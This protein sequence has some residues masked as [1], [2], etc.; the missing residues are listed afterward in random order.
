MNQLR[1]KFENP[2][3]WVKPE[4]DKAL[5]DARQA[6]EEYGHHLE[7]PACLSAALEPLHQCHGILYML[8][9]HGAALLAEEMEKT[10]Q[11]LL[12][13]RLQGHAE[14][15]EA[16]VQGALALDGYLERLNRGGED[17]PLGLLSLLNDL[18]ASRQESLVS[19]SLLFNP[20]L[21]IVPQVA[22]TGASLGRSLADSARTLRPYYQ[23]ALLTWFRNPGDS[24]SLQQMKLVVRNLES[25][26]PHPRLRQ[27]WWIAGGLLEALS[28]RGLG[29]SVTLRLL[30]GD[31]DRI[32]KRIIAGEEA[33]LVKYPPTALLKNMLFYIGRSTSEGERVSQ[34][35]EAFDLAA[36]TPSENQLAALQTSLRGKRGEALS[37]VAAELETALNVIKLR[38]EDLSRRRQVPASE[39]EPLCTPLKQFADTLSLVGLSLER[40]I[41]LQSMS[42]VNGLIQGKADADGDT[43]LEIAASLL[44]VENGLQLLAQGE[45][46]HA[47]GSSEQQQRSLRAEAEMRQL[48]RTTLLEARQ[49]IGEIKNALL[50]YLGTQQRNRNLANAPNLMNQVHGALRMLEL[51]HAA[52]LCRQLGQFIEHDILGTDIPAKAKLDHLAEAIVSLEYYLEAVA[53]GRASLDPILA[54][55]RKAVVELGYRVVKPDSAMDDNI[56]TLDSIVTRIET[57]KV[58][59]KPPLDNVISLPREDFDMDVAG[60]FAEEVSDELD[61]LAENCARLAAGEEDESIL[62][63]IRRTFHTLKGSGRVA[64]ADDIS[65]L[66]ISFERF[67][68][69][70]MCGAVPMDQKGI[71]LLRRSRDAFD[72]LLDAYLSRKPAPVEKNDLIAQLEDQEEETPEM[73][74]VKAEQRIEDA[75][76]VAPVEESGKGTAEITPL[77][78]SEAVLER[79]VEHT[80][81]TLGLIEAFVNEQHKSAERPLLPPALLVAIDKLNDAAQQSGLEEFAQTTELL[82][83]YTHNIANKNLPLS[84]EAL[85]I[86]QE[87]C[88]TSKEMLLSLQTPMREEGIPSASLEAEQAAEPVAVDNEEQASLRKIFAEE[89]E[90]LLEQAMHLLDNWSEDPSLSAMQRILHTLKGSARMAAADTI[91]NFAHEVESWLESIPLASAAEASMKAMLVGI[92]DALQEMLENLDRNLS[93]DAPIKLLAQLDSFK[94]QQVQATAATEVSISEE[95]AIT[96]QAPVVSA[97]EVGTVAEQAAVQEQPA[98]ASSEATP[99]A[100]PAA[101]A[102]GSEP[103]RLQGDSGASQ[104]EARGDSVRINAERLDEMVEL[105]AEEHILGSRIGENLDALKGNLS[106]L[107]KSVVRLQEQLRDMEFQHDQPVGSGGNDLDLDRF[108]KQQEKAKRLMESLGDVVSLQTLI[109]RQLFDADSLLGQQRRLHSQ[110]HDGL[111][112][113]RMTSFAQQTQR[114]QRIVRQSCQQ[115]NKHAELHLEGTEGAID[116]TLLDKLMGPLEH[117][118]RN[119]IAHG[120][121]G[122][123]RRRLLGKSEAGHITIA[124]A[125]EGGEYVISVSD[126]GAGIDKEKVRWRAIERG[127][128]APDTE[129]GEA[130]TL[131]LILES[132]FSTADEVSQLSGRGIGMDVVYNEVQKLAGTFFIETQPGEGTRFIIRVPFTMALNRTL[133]V[134]VGDQIYALPAHMVADSRPVS[135]DELAKHYASYP[136]R[137]EWA[138]EKYPLMYLDTIL[139]DRTTL[140]PRSD[141]YAALLLLKAHHQHAVLHVDE[142]LESRDSLLKPTGPQLNNIRGIAGATILGDGQVVLILDI[143]TLLRRIHGRLEQTRPLEV[144]ERSE[145]SHDMRRVLVVDDSITVR[146]VTERFLG[147]QGLA[148]KTAKDGIEALELLD[149]FHPDVVLLDIEMPRMDGL[150]LTR[151]MR[152]D[153][154]WQDI[155]IIM[156]TSRSGKKHRDHALQLGV[157]VFLSKPYQEASLLGHIES[158]TGHRQAEPE[159]G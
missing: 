69:G 49:D 53:D 92:F 111:L 120:I 77:A 121:E 64:G 21:E 138:G 133:M 147:R 8:E 79:F 34:L 66:A 20:D 60:I 40:Q 56:P 116:R 140:L 149:E 28:E 12:D 78:A 137:V 86:L 44:L 38:I 27:V 103:V 127:L 37:Q 7:D 6:I 129:L 16:L 153:Q 105:A 87:F 131:N 14:A 144:I 158:L 84:S 106:E 10:V 134:R 42:V 114:L 54:M 142:V 36:I 67:L 94:P 3:T 159:A 90:E 91:A 68:N 155:P 55:I 72:R 22:E 136:P 85:E 11:A 99:A 97:S 31:L 132:G 151:R 43:L 130:E 95:S 107:E 109:S 128:I 124:F 59:A 1:K 115:L 101:V 5:L 156:I 119:A 102:T 100:P 45:H 13:N 81:H 32:I 123:S 35:R 29:A 154:H 108:S 41:L 50:A 135:H 73:A 48:A 58:T 148:V 25:S 18:R 143:P 52:D 93:S 152:A 47:S 19:E 83:H 75:A 46:P 9:I 157:N 98:L 80:L 110:L 17:I 89:A 24:L 63:E 39:L 122:P 71:E 96:A 2:L 61:K 88:E 30:L 76:V 145:R 57:P 15:Y 125:K 74:A 118:V 65:E 146:K 70:V 51:D 82:F 104:G 26:S 139:N 33:E 150:E 62:A 113:T 117:I 4:L 23:A 141:E 112:D 126:D